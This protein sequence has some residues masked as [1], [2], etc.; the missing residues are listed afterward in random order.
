[1]SQSPLEQ[2]T[3]ETD[4]IILTWDDSYAIALALRE[5]HPQSDLAAVSLGMIY[6]W[7][8][9]LPNFD[10]DPQLANEDI[11]TSI[12]LEWYEEVILNE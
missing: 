8:L 10:D 2:K 11:L 3:V 4:S 7:T 12:Y 6:K 9:A 1:M 5:A